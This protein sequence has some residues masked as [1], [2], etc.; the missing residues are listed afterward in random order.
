MRN[1]VLDELRAGHARR[2]V[3]QV[4]LR[5]GNNSGNCTDRDVLR[6]LDMR[7][8]SLGT[9]VRREMCRRKVAGIYRARSSTRRLYID[10][11]ASTTHHCSR[12]CLLIESSAYGRRFPRESDTEHWIFNKRISTLPGYRCKR[13]THVDTRGHTRLIAMT[14]RMFVANIATFFYVMG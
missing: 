9:D 13:V 6:D 11:I 1:G 7:I 10:G 12:D 8:V 14:R 5:T 3:R 4:V 2:S